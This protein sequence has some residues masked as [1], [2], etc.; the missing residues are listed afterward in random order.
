MLLSRLGAINMPWNCIA[1]GCLNNCIPRD[2]QKSI[3]RHERWS[4]VP[5]RPLFMRTQWRIIIWFEDL[6]FRLFCQPR[7]PMDDIYSM[8]KHHITKIFLFAS[9]LWKLVKQWWDFRPLSRMNL[10][11]YC[12]PVESFGS[13]AGT[14]S[15]NWTLEWR[16]ISMCPRHYRA[17]QCSVFI[18]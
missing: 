12:L 17:T 5:P 15:E 8:R 2:S 6:S 10:S 16:G 9:G 13:T 4:K 11:V 1:C 14:Y 18:D 7:R 3:L